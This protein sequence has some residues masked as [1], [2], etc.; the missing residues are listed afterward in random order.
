MRACDKS[1]SWSALLAPCLQEATLIGE[2]KQHLSEPLSL[3]YKAGLPHHY[4]L[5]FLA[6]L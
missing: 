2:G 3:S 6:L 1:C 4:L 5:G